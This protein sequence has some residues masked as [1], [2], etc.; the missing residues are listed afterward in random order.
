MRI[1]YCL[2]LHME[3][4]LAKSKTGEKLKKKV[5]YRHNIE[6]GSKFPKI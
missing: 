3:L 6:A 5:L 2:G 4:C 1:K